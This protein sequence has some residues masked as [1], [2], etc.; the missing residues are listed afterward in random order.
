MQRPRVLVTGATGFLGPFA[1]AALRPVADVVTLARRGADLCADLADPKALAAAVAAAA[2]DL[3]L[4]AAALA[5]IAE[6]E[7]DPAQARRVNADA[8]A[9]L[10]QRFGARC[11]FV[12]TDLVFDGRAAPYGP[13]DPPAP[14]S[15]YGLS[16]AEGEER[17]LAAG[18]R[19]AR[20]PLLFGPDAAG[21]GATAMIR[22]ACASGRPATLFTNEYRTPL[23]AADAARGLCEVLFDGLSVDRSSGRG[24]RIVHL[25]GGERVSRWELGVRFCA[26]HGLPRAMIQPGESQDATRPRDVSLRSRWQPPRDLQAML[27]DA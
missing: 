4:H 9:A 13:L 11:L 22:T 23:H 27:A 10:A 24:A 26:L 21:R 18:G 3:V 2:P 14:L 5:R 8:S 25:S 20:I 15:A 12:S 19:V 16:K 7:R 17:V 6:C 1:V